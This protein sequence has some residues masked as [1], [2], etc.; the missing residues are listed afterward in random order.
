MFCE[1]YGQLLHG[2]DLKL[3]E[4]TISLENNSTIN[5]KDLDQKTFSIV[6]VLSQTSSE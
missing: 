2:R 5:E 3:Y 1:N 6:E 4:S